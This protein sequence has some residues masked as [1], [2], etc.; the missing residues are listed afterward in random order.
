[1]RYG[2]GRDAVASRSLYT[3]KYILCMGSPALTVW[4]RVTHMKLLLTSQFMWYNIYLRFSSNSEVFTSELLENG[5]I[6][7]ISHAIAPS[8]VWHLL[9]GIIFC[10]ASASSSPQ[11][12]SV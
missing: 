7:I 4:R 11:L 12:L 2:W 10:I 8:S 1:M 5:I 6:S 3:N 9:Y